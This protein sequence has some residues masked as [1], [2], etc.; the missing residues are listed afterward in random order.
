MNE[1]VMIEIFGNPECLMLS[2]GYSEKVGRHSFGIYRGQGH[3]HK[4][5][6]T[7]GF[8]IKTRGGVIGELK[9]ILEEVLARCTDELKDKNSLT[10]HT[11][12]S[13]NNPPDSLLVLE[14]NLIEWVLNKLRTES[15]VTTGEFFVTEA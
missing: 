5:L 14:R 15:C 9:K 3:N 10:F 13:E 4:P 6:I 8:I 1:Q 7:S 11:L 2:I 12:N